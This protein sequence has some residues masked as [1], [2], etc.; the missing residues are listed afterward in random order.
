VPHLSTW[1]DKFGDFSG[2]PGDERE[3][4]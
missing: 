3:K 1:V 4:A 2:E